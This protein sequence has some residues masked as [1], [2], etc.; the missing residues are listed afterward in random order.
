MASVQSTVTKSKYA[1]VSSSAGIQGTEASS[2]YEDCQSN[3]K[4]LANQWTLELSQGA[5]HLLGSPRGTWTA[6]EGQELNKCAV[7]IPVID[8]SI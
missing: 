3:R 1:K 2:N 6:G 5:E 8:E 4:V 7:I